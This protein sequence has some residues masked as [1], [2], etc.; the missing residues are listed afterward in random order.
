MEDI[1][2]EYGEMIIYT[3]IMLFFCGLM[4]LVLKLV[5]LIC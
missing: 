1:I 4:A 3:I 5:T 2:E